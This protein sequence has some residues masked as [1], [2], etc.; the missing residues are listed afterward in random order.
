MGIAEQCGRTLQRTSVSVNMRERLDYSCALFGPDG[1]LI[2]NAPHIPVH[3]GA[4]QEAVRCQLMHWGGDLAVGDVLLSNHPQLAGGSH[5]PDMTVI[6]PVWSAGGDGS[7]GSGSGAPR[8]LFFCACRGHHS[9]V[10]GI[11]PGSMPPHSQWLSEE[12]AAI[13]AFKL[14]TAGGGFEEARI[15][16]L[17][18][19][20]GAR[21]IPDVLSDLRAQ[22]AA[23]HR[24]IVLVHELIAACGLG[25]VHA[26]MAH[27]QA[28]A[29]GSVRSMLQAFCAA[30]RQQGG[31]SSAV[32][33]RASD[34]M[35]DGTEIC[36]QVTIDAAQGS[37]VFDFE[38][39]GAE[40]LGNTNA[41]LAVT[42]S[43]IIYCLRCMVGAEIP[44]NQGALAPISI[45]I[46]QGTILNP[47]SASAVVGGNVLTSQRVV[48]VILRAFGVCGASSGCMNN[49]TFGNGA[50]GFYET[51]C[52]G[53]G[54]GPGWHGASGVHTHMTNV[55]SFFF[56][57]LVLC[58]TATLTLFPLTE[59]F[60]CFATPPPTSTLLPPI[61]DAHHG[62][63]DPG[64]SLP[65]V[66]A[67]LSP[68][69]RQWGRGGLQRRAG[70]GA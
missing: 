59:Y 12:G 45:L 30:R 15:T 14:V 56:F 16:A 5:L 33:L 54:A 40:V 32:R 50:F 25:L 43:A 35:D 29:E 63:G 19:A 22:V 7:G 49:L 24:G 44:L 39:T 53:A 31:G 18:Q 3:L 70:G 37:A 38:G 48:D 17:L 60:C 13:V 65:S 28:A 41:P 62:R 61:L 20:A 1:G 21:N 4:M 8:I 46:P 10:G 47:S 68:A 58:G 34:F 69:Q 64:A 36:L 9:D 11:S 52:G 67:R 55:R 27:I 2:A 42:S 51:I 57:L 26:Y 6:T 66:P 23:N